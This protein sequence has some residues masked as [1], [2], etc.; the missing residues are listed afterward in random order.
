MMRAI[1]RHGLALT[2]HSSRSRFAARLNSG[3]RTL[4]PMNR[5]GWIYLVFSLAGFAISADS[6]LRLWSAAGHVTLFDL[7][8]FGGVVIVLVSISAIFALV[9]IVF[10]KRQI[11]DLCRVSNEKYQLTLSKSGESLLVSGVRL[12]RKIGSQTDDPAQFRFA[13]IFADGKIYVCSAECYKNVEQP[14][15]DSPAL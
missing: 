4:H 7:F 12:I 11:L 5:E 1:S 8:L 10:F 14:S 13:L 15:A 6:A 2:I 9:S 3:V